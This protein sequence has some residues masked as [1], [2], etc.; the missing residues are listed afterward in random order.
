MGFFDK[1]ERG[2]NN[3]MTQIGLGIL[4]NNSGHYGQFAP[5]LAGGLKD[6]RTQQAASQKQLLEQLQLQQQLSKFKMDQE[7]WNQEQEDRQIERKYT[8]GMPLELYKHQYPKPSIPT[9]MMINA[10]G[11]WA[12]DPAY[13]KGQKELK[14]AGATTITMPG[15]DA[16]KEWDKTRFE[17]I[18]NTIDARTNSA[19]AARTVADQYE[20]LDQLLQQGVET[21]DWESTKFGVEKVLRSM[22]M[23]PRL[24]DN[25]SSAKEFIAGGGELVRQKL[26]QAKGPQTDQ[27]K[28][29]L[30]T[31]EAGYDKD[32][33]ANKKL[34]SFNQSRYLLDNVFADALQEL[35]VID[36][37]KEV[38]RIYADLEKQYRKAPASVVVNGK[39]VHFRDYYRKA[40]EQGMNE[41]TIIQNWI[42]NT[43]SL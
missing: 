3:P 5:A 33:E 24:V 7:K 25:Y 18:A 4:S 30:E 41:M 15:P 13:L 2:L 10:E 16:N 6:Y 42:K 32:P 19:S 40:K 35:M 37:P 26:N 43:D 31:I 21:G 36:S 39:A 1:F 28:K 20:R 27:D 8:Q 23:N 14:E 38:S 29:F 11:S 9:G 12:Y 22:G 17:N 34:I